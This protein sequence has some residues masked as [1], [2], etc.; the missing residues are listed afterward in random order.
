MFNPE[1]ITLPPEL[2]KR[3]F[4]TYEEFGNL[5]GGVKVPTIRYWVRKGILKSIK[6]TP[7]C[8]MI[9]ISE[10]ERLRQGKLMEIEDEKDKEKAENTR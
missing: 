5:V 2:E 7:R 1:I 4:L 8:N 10:I 9:P 3:Q 6:F